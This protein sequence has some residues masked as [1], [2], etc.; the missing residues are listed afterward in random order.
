MKK[1]LICG[2]TGFIGKNITL[3]L[4]K[5][6]NYIIHAV[7]FKRP[8]YSTPENV[9]WHKADLRNP[10]SVDKL[11]KGMDIVIQAAA[12]TSGSKDIVSKPYIHVTDN[13]VIN[14]YM[15]RSSFTHKVKHFIFPSCTVMY[16]SSKKP[17]KENSFTGIIIDKYKGAGETKVYL[18]KIAKFYSMLSDTKFTIIRHSNIYGPHDKYDL[19][20]SHVF[21]ATITK[22]MR[23]TDTLEVWGSGKEIRDFLYADDL[24]DFIKTAIRKQKSQYEIYNCGSGEP[25]TVKELCE[26]IIKLSGKNIKIQF[27]KAKP[28]IPFN[29]YLNTSKAKKELGWSPKTKIDN[30]IIKTLRWWKNNVKK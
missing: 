18:E 21:G 17:T 28:T 10:N 9:I 27:N 24:V 19:D 6:K 1:V 7:R 3:G 15:F 16:P 8:K 5:N 13:A 2:A 30:G 26:K 20:K 23:A 25:I 4:A 14:S 12:T 22:V 11:I 29:M